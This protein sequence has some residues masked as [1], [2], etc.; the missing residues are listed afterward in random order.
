MLSDPATTVFRGE[1]YKRP[2]PPSKGAEASNSNKHPKTYSSNNPTTVAVLPDSTEALDSG[3]RRRRRASPSSV[4]GAAAAAAGSD[5][6]TSPM[7]QGTTTTTG[8][9]SRSSSYY[10]PDSKASQGK[11]TSTT[12]FRLKKLSRVSNHRAAPV[13]PST[14]VGSTASSASPQP[15][16][17]VDSPDSNKGSLQGQPSK[18]GYSAQV[19]DS[20]LATT[21]T[22][23]TANNDLPTK[24]NVTQ[25][26]LHQPKTNT[27][28]PTKGIEPTTDQPATPSELRP[29]EPPTNLYPIQPIVAS[30]SHSST[31]DPRDASWGGGRSS[32]NYDP[33]AG[34]KADGDGHRS[35]GSDDLD[36][37]DFAAELDAGL[38][39]VDQDSQ[40]AV[41][42]DE[43]GQGG[44]GGEAGEADFSDS[45]GFDD[46]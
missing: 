46:D 7:D 16:P 28:G 20:T 12:K 11:P 9:G 4:L 29:L 19:A 18:Q 25:L 41:E 30:V 35:D 3:R 14:T 42:A 8:A 26:N 31:I 38:E 13:V 32:R 43:D 37:D 15:E 27:L 40:R 34:A 10:S 17:A 5:R 21:T 39:P 1:T 33:T 44:G 45:S 22:S 2:A 6:G 36:I 23:T 24:T